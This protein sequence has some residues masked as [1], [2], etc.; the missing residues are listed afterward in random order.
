MFVCLFVCLFVCCCFEELIHR[1]NG[2]S[3]LSVLSARPGPA[4][5]S[6]RR[7]WISESLRRLPHSSAQQSPYGSHSIRSH[8]LLNSQET[9]D[10]ESTLVGNLRNFLVGV[11]HLQSSKFREFLR[12]GTCIINKYIFFYLYICL[13]EVWFWSHKTSLIY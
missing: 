13:E 4:P 7:P 9:L 3:V 1:T 8:Q 6:G 2:L 5:K 11:F 12:L 10:V